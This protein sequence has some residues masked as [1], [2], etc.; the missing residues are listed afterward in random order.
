MESANQLTANEG[1]WLEPPAERQGLA[2][3][4]ETIR[5]RW[6]LI[7]LCVFLTTAVAV[8]YVATATKRYEAEADLLITPASSNDITLTSLGLIRDSTD[9]NQAV[10]T[11]ARLVT[12]VEVAQIAKTALNSPDSPET[13]LDQVT[14]VPVAQSNIV[15]ITGNA[16]SPTEARDIA[17]AF[18]NSIVQERTQEMHRQINARLPPLQAQLAQD[19]AQAVGPDTLGSVITELQTLQQAPDPT[20]RVQ[21]VA[22]SPSSPAS[23]KPVLSVIAGLVAGLALG[24]GAAFATQ[25]LDPKLRRETQL[26]RLY[27]LPIL[28]RVPRESGANHGLPLDPRNMSPVTLEAYRTLRGTFAAAHARDS[29]GRVILVT[30][31][32]PSEGKTTTAVNLATSLALSG[33]RVILIEADLRRPSLGQLLEAAPSVG[34]VVSVLIENIA[35]EDALVTTRYGPNLQVLLADYEGGWIAELFSIPA[36]TEMVSEARRMA[37]YVIIDSAPLNEVI[38]AMPLAREA[39]DIL[40]VVRLGQSRLDK[41]TQL[42]ELLAENGVRPTGF[43]VVGT[44]RPKR[45][46]YHY[47]ESPN[48]NGGRR[49]RGR[50]LLSGTSSRE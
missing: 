49:K 11:A 21:T 14:A 23:P 22:V 30:G 37:D 12:N 6:W 47:Y 35:L 24:I 36:A 8:L 39:D 9:P 45:G 31:A 3:Y 19:P 4:I 10:Q 46:E 18:A 1:D 34:G 43:A 15:A 48:D 5:E 50:R 40:M 38:D 13:L 20:V 28:A 33:N 42:G 44:P 16:T 32:S 29:T 17:N 26:R 2:R 7:A 25:G 27:R 41:I